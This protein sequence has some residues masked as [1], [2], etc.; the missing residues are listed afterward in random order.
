MD[1]IR[2]EEEQIEA[3]QRW[4]DENG[5]STVIAVVL[6]V[7]GVFGWQA[8]QQ[9]QDTQAQAASDVYQQLLETVTDQAELTEAQLRSAEHVVDTLKA[10]HSSSSYTQFATLLLAKVYVERGDLT[11]AEQQLRLAL[12]DANEKNIEVM[13]RLRLATVLYAQDK[14]DEALALINNVEAGEFRAAYDELRGDIYSDKGEHAE[15]LTAYDLANEHSTAQNKQLLEFKL[16]S[17]KRKSGSAVVEAAP[18]ELEESAQTTN[19]ES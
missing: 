9:Q 1:D 7:A 12:E 5:K 16:R 14:P 4:W 19:E 6:G 15:A 3:I 17:A 2:T 10:E 11:G 18:V 8:W 13:V